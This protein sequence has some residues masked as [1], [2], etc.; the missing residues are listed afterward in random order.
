[1]MPLLF[2]ICAAYVNACI[3]TGRSYPRKAKTYSALR[4]ILEKPFI[5]SLLYDCGFMGTQ[6]FA[7]PAPI[8]WAAIHNDYRY[9]R[10]FILYR[11]LFWVGLFLLAEIARVVSQLRR[12]RNERVER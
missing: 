2:G 4:S 8:T 1:M 7:P 5:H 3:R 12:T 6:G 10:V 9:W 11:A